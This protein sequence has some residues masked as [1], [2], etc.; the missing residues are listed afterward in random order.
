MRRNGRS[1]GLA[2]VLVLCLDASTPVNAQAKFDSTEDRLAAA[3]ERLS[4][5]LP[6][7]VTM[8][9]NVRKPL[10]E[11]AR[12][13]CDRTA[14]AEFGQ[15]LQKEGYRREAANAHVRFSE[16]CKG[17]SQSLQ[18]AANIL[19]DLSDYAAAVKVATQLIA[20]MPYG[21]NGYYLRAV[22]HDR[23]G[24]SKMAIDDYVTAIEL[25]GSKERISSVSYLGIARNHER[26][27][28]FC[29]AILAIEGWVALNPVRNDTSQT[30]AIIATYR[31]KGGCATLDKSN[32]V[33]IPITRR[34]DVVTLSAVINGVTG[35]FILDTGATY[36][37]LTN[38]F[39]QKSKAEIDQNSVIKLNTANGI[40][41]GKRG[42]VNSIRVRSLESKDVPIVVQADD[43]L[44]MG[45]RVD[46]LLGMSF[47]SRF[48][49]TMDSTSVRLRKRAA[50]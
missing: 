5:K 37:G 33:V 16:T 31:S 45:P 21:D 25:F 7:L 3:M 43:K 28:Q 18:M 26:L 8:R 38:S 32:E 17:H 9:P 46:G 23:A 14:I 30:R 22:A 44:N 36:V 50:R 6:I 35:I 34:G 1:V 40:A 19:L 13:P 24:E 42:R 39:A 15:A 11:L 47:L 12:E 10:D 49:L 4:I 29:D 20:L 41:E 2:L 48:H 27:G